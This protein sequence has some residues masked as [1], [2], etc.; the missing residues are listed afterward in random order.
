[1]IPGNVELV[2]VLCSMTVET[3]GV[4]AFLY[5]DGRLRPG[6]R[7]ERRWLPATSEAAVLGAFLFGPLYGGPA[8]I[9][10]FAK[11]RGALGL[12]V[13][14]LCAVAVVAADVGTQLCAAA[15]IDWLAL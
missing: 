15:A 5:A 3:G 12:V 2:Q 7:R 9:I 14:L 4:A 13:G 6:R 10:H 1:M 8:L 11:S